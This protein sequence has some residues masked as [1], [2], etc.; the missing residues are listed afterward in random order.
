MSQQRNN[1]VATLCICWAHAAVSKRTVKWLANSID[2]DQMLYSLLHLHCLLRSVC[3]NTSDKYGIYMSTFHLFSPN[4]FLYKSDITY[5]KEKHLVQCDLDFHCL[6]KTTDLFWRPWT[7]WVGWPVVLLF[8]YSRRAF[9]SR[10]SLSDNTISYTAN[11]KIH[12][13]ITP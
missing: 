2:S 3:P 8:T 5:P 7:E 9:F 6:L 4:I 10:Y 12:L 1:V 13:T 11:F